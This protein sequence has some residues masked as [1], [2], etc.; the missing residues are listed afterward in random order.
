MLSH[1]APAS[2]SALIAALASL[3]I[4]LGACAGGSAQPSPSAPASAEASP[5]PTLEP[6][7]APGSVSFS[8]GSDQPVVTRA[9]TGIDEA[10][11]N[12][13]AIIEHDGTFHMFANVF[14]GWPGRVLVAHLTSTDGLGWTLAQEAPA[15]DSDDVPFGTAGADVST[16]F[17]ADDG[18]WVLIFETVTS[19]DPWLLGRATAP[20]PD[21][22]WTIDPAPILEPGPAGTWDAGGLSWPS[23]VRTSDG[24]AMYY[25]ATDVPRGDGV[26]AMASSPDG[27]SWTKA[28]EPVLVAS[29]EWEQGRLDR[30]RVVATDA[31]YLMV[32]SGSD[33]TDRGVA[34]SSDGVSWTR[35]GELPAITRDDFPVDGRCW[36]AALLNIDGTLHYYL[37]IGVVSASRGTQVY[38]ATAALP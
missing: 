38:L 4:A 25:T 7:P 37:E 14:T 35:D 23:V 30:A 29:A 11:I 27:V 9:L 12:P 20:S 18:T 15:L 8:F 24:F 1:A 19:L 28:D 36:D 13:G 26:I 31:G 6:T 2:R 16:G 5:E 22:P 17:V 34:F 21:G 32:Y 33:L 3:A 10:Y